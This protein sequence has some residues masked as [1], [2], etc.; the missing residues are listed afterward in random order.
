MIS[1]TGVHSAADAEND[2]VATVA[3][4]EYFKKENK[5]YVI[6][7][8]NVDDT[9]GIC[10]S[11]IKFTE[12]RVEMLKKGIVDTNMIFEENQIHTMQYQTPFGNL[13]FDINTDK[14]RVEEQDDRIV[15]HIQ[16]GLENGNKLISRCKVKIEIWERP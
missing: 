1:V 4:G 9:G 3:Q 5:H 15:I 10:R 13:L 11:R 6:Y 12:E 8:E 7:Q 2:N 14:I 16:Y